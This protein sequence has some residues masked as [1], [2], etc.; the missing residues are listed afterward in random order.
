MNTNPEFCT[1]FKTFNIYILRI[2][3]LIRDKK[4]NTNSEFVYLNFEK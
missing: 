3:I 1:I 2:Y 4:V